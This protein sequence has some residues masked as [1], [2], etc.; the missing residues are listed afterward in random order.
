MNRLFKIAQTATAGSG[1]QFRKH[2]YG[3]GGIQSF[4]RD[5]LALANASVDGPR[6]IIVGAE[7]DSRDQRHFYSIDAADFSGKPSYQALA[8]E[9]IEPPLR[10]SYKAVSIEGKR[11]GV[12]EIGDSQDRPYM[13]RIDYSEQLRR[14]DAY[15]R[16]RSSTMKMGRRQLSELFERK[17]RDSV[18]AGDIEIGFPGEIIHK[19]LTLDCCDLSKLPSAEASKKLNQL[20]DIRQKAKRSGST[21]VMARLTHARL[22]GPDNPYVDRSPDELMEEIG[23][24]RRKYRDQDDHF[25]FESRAERVQMVVYNQGEEPIID[26]S[27]SLIM[28]NHNAFYVAETLPKILRDDALA[29]RTADE[30]AS[31][32]SVT[33]K[34]DAVQVTSKIGDI[35]VGAPVDVFA[36][37]LRICVGKDLSGKRFGIRYA[38]HGQ[39]LRSP[40]K[41]NLRLIFR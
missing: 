38:L 3:R 16:S 5:V 15:V 31:Y 26:A 1:V 17:F 10:I 22:F 2:S 13:M 20:I 29:S 37:P 30:I 34:D 25:L 7:I 21:T 27:L 9:Y 11:V 24:L 28:P 6:Y 32:P 23:E 18:S 19:D 39:N 8:N 36:S 12:F 41:G 4:L 14:G 35:E 33:L 40:A